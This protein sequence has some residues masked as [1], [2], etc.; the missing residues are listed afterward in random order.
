MEKIDEITFASLSG[1]CLDVCLASAYNSNSYRQ[2]QQQQQLPQTSSG[3]S[4]LLRHHSRRGADPVIVSKSKTF[5]VPEGNGVTLPCDV[6]NM[7]ETLR[8]I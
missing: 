6:Q 1:C 8:P 7:G 5:R 4:M 2:Q 3:N